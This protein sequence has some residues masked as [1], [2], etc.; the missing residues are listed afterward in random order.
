MAIE[1]L[2]TLELLLASV[3]TLF[4][5][6][7][8]VAIVLIVRIRKGYRQE[9]D[10]LWAEQED[11]LALALRG[12][13]AKISGDDIAKF[14]PFSP[15]YPY[16]SRDVVA[17]FDTCDYLVFNG[18]VGGDITE[19][20]FQ[21][22]KINKAGLRLE[23]RSLRDCIKAGRVRWETWRFK[24]KDECW[25]TKDIPPSHTPSAPT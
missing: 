4:L 10:E 12:Q 6:L 16:N 21:E 13:K 25:V 20:V 8:I 17:L 2:T 24:D 5:V 22:M 7:L 3:G 23:Q 18:R 19:V 14:C 11:K 9:I 1:Y 15:D